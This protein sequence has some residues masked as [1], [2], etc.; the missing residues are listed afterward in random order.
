MV[1]FAALFDGIKIRHNYRIFENAI[2]NS[3]GKSILSI[4]IRYSYRISENTIKN[5]HGRICGRSN[6]LD[7]VKIRHNYRIFENA[8]KNAYGRIYLVD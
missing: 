2:K 4:K 8:I 5:A 6:L 7:G 1:E 3:Y